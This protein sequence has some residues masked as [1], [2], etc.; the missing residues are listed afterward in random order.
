[1]RLSYLIVGLL[2]LPMATG[3]LCG[4]EPECPM[5]RAA[6]PACHDSGPRLGAACWCAQSSVITALPRDGI[7]RHEEAPQGVVGS[8]MLDRR[9][10]ATAARAHR[11]LTRPVGLQLDRLALY[12]TLLI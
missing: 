5:D 11:W 10:P 1:M 12:S 8:A 2:L 3:P 6:H 7:K 4:S 9:A